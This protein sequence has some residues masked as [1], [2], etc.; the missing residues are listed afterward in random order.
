[1]LISG[2]DHH[3]AGL[4]TMAERLAPNQQGPAG[5][6]RLSAQPDVATLAERLKEGGYRTL[7]AGKWHLGLTPEQDPHARGF[8]RELRAAAGCGQPLSA[9]DEAPYTENGVRSPRCR[10][11]SIR[12]TTSPTG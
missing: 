7:M 11:T 5:L 10:R 8:E 12:P 1:M 3:R 6:R 2:T 9:L 4:G